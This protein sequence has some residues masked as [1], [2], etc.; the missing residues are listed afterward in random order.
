MSLYGALFGG[1]SGLRAQSSKIGMVS[2]NIANVN[3][4]GYK[5]ASAAFQTLV[6]NSTAAGSYQTGGV[7]SATNL[8]VSKQGL[9]QSTESA[10]DIAISG[11]GFFVVKATPEYSTLSTPYYTRAG[12]FTQDSLGNFINSQGF[13]LQGWPL[14]REGRLP[15]EQGNLNTTSFTDLT[16]LKTVNV[17][18]A[19][20]SAQ[21]TSQVSLGAN[22][23]ESEKVYP[24]Q[25]GVFSLDTNNLTNRNQPADAILVGAEYGMA[26]SDGLRRG[27]SF[28]I[29][30][31]T[32]IQHTYEY[33]GY[34]VGR[35]ITTPG[36]V[37]DS[38]YNNQGQLALDAQTALEFSSAS[39]TS[40]D[41]KISNHNL[42]NGDKI[43]LTNITGTG[44]PPK[45]GNTPI[46]ELNGTHTITWVDANTVRITVNTPYAASP[47]ATNTAVT[48]APDDFSVNTRVSV[49]QG[50][51]MDA[52]DPNGNLLQLTGSSGFTP[53][54]LK[55]SVTTDS[56][57]LTFQYTSSAPN[58][59]NGQFNSLS[60]L[61]EAINTTT[62]LTARVTNG[63]LVI[64][65]A[66]A[67]SG[68]TFTNGDTVGAADGSKR[69]IDWVSEF[70]LTD[71]EHGTSGQ[72]F[73]S[74][75][76]LANIVNSQEGLSASI[77]NP[78]ASPTLHL[79]VD[80]PLTTI[81]FTDSAPGQNIAAGAAVTFPGGTYVKGDEIPITIEGSLPSGTVT[82]LLAS[83]AGFNFASNP[84]LGGLPNGEFT[85]TSI[86]TASIPNTFTIEVVAPQDMVIAPT[87]TTTSTA[88]RVGLVGTSN[89]GSILAHL[90][91]K[92]NAAGLSLNGASYDAQRTSG[93]LAPK[94]DATGTSGENMASGDITA[95]FS[96]NIRVYDALGS[97]HDVKMSF[98]KIATNTWAVEV[99]AVP[100]DDITP[101]GNLVNG[102]IATGSV[103]FNGDGTLRSVSQSM[104]NTVDVTWR[105]GS[106]ASQLTFNLGTAGQEFGTPG[107][108]TIGEADGLSQFDSGYNV[109]FATQNGAPVGQLVSVAIDKDGFVIASY[110]NG[111]TQSLYKL[112]IADFANPDGLQAITG[113]VF[114]QTRESGEQNL[115][116]AGTNGTGTVVSAALEQ[117][118]VDLA[119][120]LTDMIVAQRSYQAN[121]KVIKTADELLD[122]LNNI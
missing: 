78:L 39:T 35:S 12:S 52:S 59:A 118:N 67:N 77:D 37:G 4:I 86:D 53:D 104:L 45:Y 89:Q 16:S 57:T 68:V 87:T 20:G 66:D 79:T 60:T 84:L 42:I 82:P 69:G 110:S 44:A 51:I 26:G 103:V 41:L 6:V 30:T 13:Y 2:D 49:F 101:Q 23:K 15:G 48:G 25:E 92:N 105:N 65:A 75:Q 98:I 109:N 72:R 43:T 107:A 46:T 80:D 21:A 90:G 91:M 116:E 58:T 19:S 27:D 114:A 100:A 9:L 36:Q 33:G 120:Q 3:T 10:T 22:L 34:T 117:S 73:N 97:G 7:R 106:S 62:A 74:V 94:Y 108:L 111:E 83:L 102:Q 38:N 50:N 29:T 55:F 32:G 8:N 76:G 17:E 24:G 63:R 64:S 11:G 85:I 61:A 88:G 99:Y 93:D 113:N 54:A 18:S 96:R 122:Q 31:G 119:E 5:Q 115:R 71:V 40:F 1:V 28:S 47:V 70:G 56:G 121:T 95:Q 14:D 81:N 112:P